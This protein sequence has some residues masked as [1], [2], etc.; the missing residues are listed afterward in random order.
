MR[1]LNRLMNVVSRQDNQPAS[2]IS[3]REVYELLRNE[4]RRHIIEY[5]A[6]MESTTT[7][8]GEIADYLAENGESR[9]AAYVACI[10]SHLPRMTSI[11]EYDDRGKEVTPRPALYS[12]YQIQRR[13]E[14]MLNHKEGE[15]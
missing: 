5:L 3:P 4:R 6:T 12:V 1:L 13:V 10:Q 9:D 14:Q 2:T 11:I 8:A 7:D 15:A